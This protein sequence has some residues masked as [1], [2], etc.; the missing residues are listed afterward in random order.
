[1]GPVPGNSFLF[2]ALEFLVAPCQVMFGSSM[3]RLDISWRRG[4]NQR[5]KR[6]LAESRAQNVPMATKF[7]VLVI[8]VIYE[9]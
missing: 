9:K 8:C 5:L 4:E 1:M 7:V 2:E 3:A 6:C